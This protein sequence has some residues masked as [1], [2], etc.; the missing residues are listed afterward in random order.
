MWSLWEFFPGEIKLFSVCE[1]ASSD[2]DVSTGTYYLVPT[3]KQAH[4]QQYAY[5]ATHM[6]CTQNNHK[7]VFNNEIV[8]LHELPP[9]HDAAAKCKQ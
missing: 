8:L 4:I 6:I 2:R 5:I 1:R 3:Y 9:A 7:H